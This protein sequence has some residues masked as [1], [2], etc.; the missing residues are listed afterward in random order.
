MPESG[1]EQE[2]AEPTAPE[3]IVPETPEETDAQEEQTGEAAGMDDGDAGDEGGET[4]P[5]SGETPAF[6]A[7]AMTLPQ[8][9]AMIVLRTEAGGELP[10]N[11]AVPMIREPTPLE[12]T[13]VQTAADG[14]LWYLVRN[15]NNDETGYIEAY[16]VEEVTKEVA[17]AAVRT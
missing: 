17:E 10:Q 2:I 7:Y 13:G 5:E 9:N 6:P 4:E 14:Q 11:G 8:D 1:E 12:V 3:V 15:M 16:K